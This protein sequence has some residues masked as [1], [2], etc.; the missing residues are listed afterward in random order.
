M[1]YPSIQVSMI[2]ISG[3]EYEYFVMSILSDLAGL[4]S[5]HIQHLSLKGLDFLARLVRTFLSNFLLICYGLGLAELS[6]VHTLT[7]RS[8]C[9][10][11]LS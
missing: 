1:L 2:I 11:N 5:F 3:Y 9:T 7:C 4:F 10:V 8:Y 6:Q